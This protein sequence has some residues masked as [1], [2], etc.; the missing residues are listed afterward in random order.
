MKNL[1]E[2]ADTKD[3]DAAT[4][5]IIPDT[6]TTSTNSNQNE[7]IT[8]IP[9]E[10]WSSI[11]NNAIHEIE[12]FSADSGRRIEAIDISVALII[13]K[14]R[15]RL[16]NKCLSDILKLLRILGVPN[17]PT[18][19]WKCKKLMRKQSTG[20]LCTK[21]RSIC[22]SCEHMPDEVNCCNQCDIDYD[23]IVPTPHIPVFYH[24]DIG[25]Q[26]ESI[27]LH[28]SDFVFQ[29]LSLT[30][31][32]IMHDIVDGSFYRNHFKQETDSFITLTMN[33][34]GV[35]P[36]IVDE[37]KCLEAGHMFQL[38]TAD[39]EN[40]KE[41]F[42]KVFL[43]TSCC[44]KPA[45][46][47]V[48]CLPEPTARFGCGRCEI[49]GDVV[50]T[51]GG[52]H[53][54][55]FAIDANQQLIRR[56]NERYDE[57]LETMKLNNEE[58]ESLTIR[59]DIQNAT[60]RH[61]QS[62]KGLKRPCI[63]RE[64]KHFDVGQSFVKRLLKLWLKPLYKSELWSICTHLSSLAVA[65]KRVKFPSTTTRHPRSLLDYKKF[66][67][68]ELRVVLLCGYPIFEKFMHK[69][70]YDHFKQLVLAVH[71]AESRALTEKDVEAAHNL[72]HNFLLQFPNLYGKRH[73]VQV[74]HS[75]MHLSESIRDFGPLT[76]Y[77]TFNFESLLG[78]LTRSTKSTS[79]HALEMMNNLLYLRDAHLHLR[80]PEICASLGKF[81]LSLINNCHTADQ[82]SPLIKVQ[83][84]LNISDPRITELFSGAVQFY[85]S[86][87]IG[88]IRLTTSNYSRK[89]NADD[90]SIVYRA[91]DEVHY[92]R[93]DR[94]FTVDGGDVLFQI[95]SLASSTH[96]TCETADEEYDY[97]E[98]EM[99]MIS[100][101]T[102]TCI[103][104]AK[105]II[106]K[107]VF[108]LQPNSYATF[109]RFPNLVESS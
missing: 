55:S 96:F 19:L 14:A 80:D 34:D 1:N 23:T 46:C 97:N 30:S 56:S 76:N 12:K 71:L 52:G 65:L 31:S 57:L 58:L 98:I 45:Q 37:L 68:N 95:F 38:R 22:P 74:I 104:K 99:G 66:K 43:I 24:F 39:G 6:D 60:L 72:S 21:K 28:T 90:S 11:L 40:M 91:G 54:T 101:G 7:N 109:V 13:L 27:L 93:I 85:S 106:E 2:E 36:C 9:T 83:H 86:V 50:E 26:L 5:N 51:E 8:S 79:R 63:L 17:V 48:Q 88:R 32:K 70:Y 82:S 62:E 75:L 4:S 41:I 42:V 18:S 84:L 49:K 105:Q 61:K 92:G 102:T 16:S 29:D 94:I 81:L 33:I 69:K 47:L 73:N 78:L 103:I 53:V 100:A 20:H 87:F 35:H 3:R 89:K 59:R 64:L 107:C 25:L 44:D 67:A 10:S 108:Y 15:H 77:T